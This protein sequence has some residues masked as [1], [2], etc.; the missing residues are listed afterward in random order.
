MFFRDSCR[1]Q[2]R[3]A[4]V[5]GWVAN[6]RDGSSVEAVFEGDE[7]AVERMIAWCHSGP[8][9]AVVTSVQVHDEKPVGETSFRVRG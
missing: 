4:G 8:P 1:E 2:A 6:R 7:P 5:G 3:L 9:R